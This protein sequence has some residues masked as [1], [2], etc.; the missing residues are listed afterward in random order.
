MDERKEQNK[1]RVIQM[2]R[3][4]GMSKRNNQILRQIFQI[5]N[6]LLWT[7]MYLHVFIRSL[8]SQLLRPQVSYRVS[9][10][11]L[12]SVHRKT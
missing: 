3:E 2:I 12:N 1:L 10:R 4:L 9:E 7:V 8:F 11:L 6:L 5:A